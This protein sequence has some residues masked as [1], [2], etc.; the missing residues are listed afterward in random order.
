MD[1]NDAGNPFEPGAPLKKKNFSK[2]TLYFFLITLVLLSIICF[3]LFSTD[4][5]KHAHSAPID[6]SGVSAWVSSLA[7]LTAGDEKVYR[8]GS[9]AECK[10]H[11]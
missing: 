8:T 9:S 6:R 2:F 7:M 1:R 4:E 11:T 3:V 5:V 10:R